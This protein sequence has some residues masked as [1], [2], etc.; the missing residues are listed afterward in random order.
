MIAAV[1]RAEEGDLERSGTAIADKQGAADGLLPRLTLR[2]VSP[3]DDLDAT[4]A[5]QLVGG[6]DVAHAALER[7]VEP[8]NF[9]PL[10]EVAIDVEGG[11]RTQTFRR[12]RRTGSQRQC[13][14]Q[15]DDGGADGE[16]GQAFGRHFG[17][18]SKT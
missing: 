3:V 13:E 2:V 17:K 7:M 18:I 12:C 5:L 9:I 11:D 14:K 16:H 8:G 1:E 6:I 15:G 4:V 10:P